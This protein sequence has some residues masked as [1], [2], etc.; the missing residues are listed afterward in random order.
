ML[1]NQIFLVSTLG[2]LLGPIPGH[3]CIVELFLPRLSRFLLKHFQQLIRMMPYLLPPLAHRISNFLVWWD[4]VGVEEEL[5]DGV[6]VALDFARDALGFPQPDE[7]VVVF[8]AP[9]ERKVCLRG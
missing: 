4:T 5:V 7:E 9:P 8:R 3:P 2:N 1:A 6:H